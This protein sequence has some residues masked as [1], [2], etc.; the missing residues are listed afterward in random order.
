VTDQLI[1][2]LAAM[3]NLVV[4]PL[5]CALERAHARWVAAI[6]ADERDIEEA[7]HHALAASRRARGRR[8]RRRDA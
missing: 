6:R 4:T 1:D 7:V 5:A 8:Y 3:V 2:P